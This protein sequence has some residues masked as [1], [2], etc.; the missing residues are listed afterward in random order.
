MLGLFLGAG[1]SYEAG[2]P[3]VWEVTE[4]IKS[5]LTPEHLRELNEGW[6]IQGTG[7][8][9]AVIDDLIS[10][11]VRPDMHYEA[12]LGYMEA[13][14]RRQR[15]QAQNYH[16][17]YSWLVEV[18]YNVLYLRH[19]G[20]FTFLER[21]LPRYDG[22]A[23]LLED[24]SPLRIFSLNHDVIIEAVAA[25]L[26]IT[27]YSGFSPNT[28]TLPRRGPAGQKIGEIRAEVLTKNELENAAM[29]YPN[30]PKPG[31]YLMKIHGGLDIFTFND[32]HDLMKLL[33]E[34]SD[35]KGYIEALRIANEDLFYLLPGASGGKAK[36][37][38]QITYADDEG[39]MQFLRRSLLAGAFKFDARGTQVLP[40]SMLKHFRDNLNFLTT[41]VC[42]GYGFGDIH[43]N[44]VLRDWLAFSAER[45][46]EIVSPEAGAIPSFLQHL[47]PQVT[48][49][50]LGAMD[51][52]DKAA[53]IIRPSHEGM[54]KRVMHAKRRLGKTR[55]D[56]ILR[57]F[58]AE[59]NQRMGAGFIAR[60]QE[61]PLLNGEPD[62][63]AIGDPTETAKKWAEE[64]KLSEED[65]LAALLVRL[66]QALTP[67]GQG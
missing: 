29:Y 56:E 39:V 54:E 30:P 50:K 42:I 64:L 18:V 41:L 8:P 17:L 7:F 60:L 31:I 27:L 59:D 61:L 33:P 55:S 36:G 14:F 28:V 63:S 51:Y 66:D 1:A 49:T 22:I 38:N 10:V 13:Q 45:R 57:E 4:E 2:M 11:L 23:A 20:N 6:H 58:L 43:I 16:G 48:V 34:G 24:N 37:T 35:W 21:Y 47:A 44:L 40:M 26:G 32:G 3:L 5:W 67:G 25:R 53:G 62:F 9:D 15:A 46:I 19:I 65:F 12:V 52:F